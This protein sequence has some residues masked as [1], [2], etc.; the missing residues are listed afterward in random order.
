MFHVF[1]NDAFV[2]QL[3]NGLITAKHFTNSYNAFLITSSG[4]SAPIASTLD[5]VRGTG[6]TS[7]YG[8]AKFSPDGSKL[9]MIAGQSASRFAAVFDFNITM[10][11]ISNARTLVVDNSH[12]FGAAFSPNGCMFY[13]GES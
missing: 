5:P 7:A 12:L 9:A 4:I 8:Q 6:F 11:I 13:L 1:T 3:Q 10:G 2:H